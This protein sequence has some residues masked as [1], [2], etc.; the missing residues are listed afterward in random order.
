MKALQLSEFSKFSIVILIQKAQPIFAVLLA[1]FILK[2]RPSKKFYI[3]AAISL[4]AIYLL[5]FEFKS[6]ALL[7]KNNLLA[8]MYSLLAA[9]SFG[10]ATVFGKKVVYK[11]SFLT[12]TFYRFFFYYSGYTVLCTF[13]RKYGKKSQSLLQQHRLKYLCHHYCNIWTNSHTY[14]LQ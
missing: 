13:F 10:S 8:A 6:P 1:F 4:I 3:I 5:T 9:F 14:L 11:F 2:E 12:S 7:P